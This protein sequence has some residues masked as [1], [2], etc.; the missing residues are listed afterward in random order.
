MHELHNSKSKENHKSVSWKNRLI[1][2]TVEC[3]RVDKLRRVNLNQMTRDV[4]LSSNIPHDVMMRVC[5]GVRLKHHE[6]CK[7][8]NIDTDILNFAT[9]VI[10]LDNNI[11]KSVW[12]LFDTGDACSI[13]K[14]S[15]NSLMSLCCGSLRDVFSCVH[16]ENTHENK[17]NKSNKSS[18]NN[19]DDEII[20]P[21][22]KHL[23][24]NKL[25]IK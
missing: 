20:F 11:V 6:T 21:S 3:E 14:I 10:V 16:D 15:Q 7:I 9:I 1:D 12:E 19:Y 23:P 8:M 5:R 25:L 4:F 18:Q 17:S 2:T 13:E 24:V 22:G